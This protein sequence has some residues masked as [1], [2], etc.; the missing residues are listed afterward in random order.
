MVISLIEAYDKVRKNNAFLKDISSLKTI[1]LPLEKVCVSYLSDDLKEQVGNKS[2]FLFYK[3]E[4]S[5]DGNDC[6]GVHFAIDFDSVIYEVTPQ[7]IIVDIEASFYAPKVDENGDFAEIGTPTVFMLLD[8]MIDKRNTPEGL[9]LIPNSGRNHSR[10]HGFGL[11]SY[12]VEDLL[13]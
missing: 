2:K 8:E 11:G 1:A 7:S 13:S 9:I 12:T 3:F 10:N 5:P 4:N 6:Y